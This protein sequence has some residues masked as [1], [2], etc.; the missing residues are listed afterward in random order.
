M[1]IEGFNYKE[2]AQNL[3]DQAKELVPANFGEFEKNYIV[4]TLL[5]FSN[6]AGEAL[7]NDT[8]IK[9]TAEQATL[10]TQIIAEWSFH[11]SVDLVNSGIQ[12]EYWDGVMQKIAFTIFE[13]GKQ[14]VIQKMDQDQTL[15][16]IEHQVKKTYKEA[17]DELKKRGIIDEEVFEQAA[18]QSNIDAMLQQIEEEKA[19]QAEMEAQAMAQQQQQ[20]SVAEPQRQAQTDLS[21]NKIL[22]LTALALLFKTLSADK[23]RTMLSRLSSEDADAVVQYMQMNDLENRV[24]KGVALRCLKEI[25]ASLPE[26]KKASPNKII[27][28]MQKIFDTTSR[29][30]VEM[31][32]HKERPFVKKFVACAYQG[33]YYE[34]P[35]KVALIVAQH[36]KDSV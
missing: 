36:I 19:A 30:R 28:D 9:F 32:I 13:I 10:I 35:P 14:S 4:N 33:E 15:E 31:I 22:K 25:Q 11:K 17:I 5:N 21:N 29:E 8:E 34:I 2:F 20:Q 23:V 16:I 6:L 1:P 26:P 24:D 3:S 12:P 18:N 27:F 7:Y